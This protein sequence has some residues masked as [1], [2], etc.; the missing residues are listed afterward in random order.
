[1][2]QQY[3]LPDLKD[4]SQR[5][6]DRQDWMVFWSFASSFPFGFYFSLLDNMI[7]LVPEA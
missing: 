1:M 7:A 6:V 2:L 3:P 5:H 4:L